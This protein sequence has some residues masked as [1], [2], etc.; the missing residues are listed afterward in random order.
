MSN[1][2]ALI[3]ISYAMSLPTKRNSREQNTHVFLFKK[4]K[5]DND[6]GIIHRLKLLLEYTWLW[7]LFFV[8]E[9]NFE[10]FPIMGQQSFLLL[11][12][13]HFDMRKGESVIIFIGR[14]LCRGGFIYLRQ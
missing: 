11:L 2:R 3:P 12:F 4:K 5:K 6:L 1:V 7:W 10:L 8:E 14:P 13:G 9:Y